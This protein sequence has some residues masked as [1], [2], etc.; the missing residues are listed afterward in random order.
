MRYRHL[1][2]CSLLLAIALLTTGCVP[3]AQ[4]PVPVLEYGQ[5]EATGNTDLLIL[6]RGIGG[7]H[8]DFERFGLIDQVRERKLPVDIVVPNAHYG[9]YKSESLVD[10]IKEDI[11]NPARQQGY[12]RF[13]LAGFSM[14]GL[15]SLFYIREHPEDIEA[16]MLVSPFMGWGT[17]R[18]EIEAAGGIRNWDAQESAID[19]WQILIWTF[20]QDYIAAP[21]NYPPVY[22]GYGN[23]DRVTKNG[24]LLL[25]DALSKERIFTL[26]GGHSYKTFRALWSEHLDRLE[27]DVAGRVNGSFAATKAVRHNKE[28]PP[29][30]SPATPE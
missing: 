6:L 10:R 16:V 3:K 5:I 1:F 14:G 25:S 9:Y 15:G 29:E 26:P 11:I 28:V 19:N 12:Q 21:N 2:R 20:I 17:I 4:V 8:T 13:W 27:K 18:R 22:L 7:S 30:Q 23:N 24:P